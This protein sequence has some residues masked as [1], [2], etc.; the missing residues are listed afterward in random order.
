[1]ALI[2]PNETRFS[3]DLGGMEFV[4]ALWNKSLAARK[5]WWW[6]ENRISLAL[7][8]LLF[9]Y[10]K[11]FYARLCYLE[12]MSHS[13]FG[14]AIDVIYRVRRAQIKVELR[15]LTVRTTYRYYYVL[16][17]GNLE[18][19]KT[20]KDMTKK[21]SKKILLFNNNKKSKNRVFLEMWK[22][23]QIKTVIC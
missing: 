17:L 2:Y 19:T 23:C 18:L 8:R 16:R 9:D 21:L 7:C 1:M 22:S 3:N 4:K 11:W 12:M 5:W 15:S 20:P 6:Q 14:D 10:V 13:S